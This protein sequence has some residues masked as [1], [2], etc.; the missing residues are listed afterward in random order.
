MLK[1]NKPAR[2]ANL[3]GLPEH[4][5]LV[6]LTK[7]ADKNPNRAVDVSWPIVGSKT[8]VYTLS[9]QI[10]LQKGLIGKPQSSTGPRMPE[11][12]LHMETLADP[13]SITPPAPP[14]IIW[15]HTTGDLELLLNL[16]ASEVQGHQKHNDKPITG[17]SIFQ[18]TPTGEFARPTSVQNFPQEPISKALSTGDHQTFGQVTLAG[19]LSNVDLPSV[20]QSVNLCKM[21][22]KLNLY[23][24]TVQA[25]AYFTDGTLVHATAQHAVSGSPLPLTPDQ[26]LLELLTWETGTFRFQPGWPA[27]TIT[28]RRRLESFLL[29]GATLIDYINSLEKQGFTEQSALSIVRANEGTLDEALKKGIPVE[30]QLQRVIYSKISNNTPIADLIEDLPKSIW[31]PIVFNLLN[32]QLVTMSGAK[33]N[34]HEIEQIELDLGLAEQASLQLG[35]PESGVMHF[36]MFVYFLQKEAARYRKS[37]LPFSM[38][39]FDITCE[40]P[41]EMD[42]LVISVGTAFQD[43]KQPY[44]ILANFET[45]YTR[46]FALLLPYKS[47]AASY[48]FIDGLLLSLKATGFFTQGKITFGLASF[49]TDATDVHQ[50]ASAASNAKKRAHSKGKQIATFSGV[51]LQPWEELHQKG[52]SAIASENLEMASDIWLTALTEAENFEETDARLIVTL[53]RLSSIY[54]IQRKFDMAEPLLKLSLDLKNMSGLELEMITTLDQ[55]GRCYYEQEKYV[56]SEQSMLRSAELCSN[57][58]GPEHESLGNVFHNLA[59][60]YHVQNRLAEALQSYQSAVSIKRRVLGREHPE[61]VQLTENY[62]KLLRRQ[63]Q[64]SNPQGEDMFITGRWKQLRFDPTAI[65]PSAQ[66]QQ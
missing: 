27:T 6:Q 26:I 53:D 56:E 52:D 22:G 10:V 21:T 49:P 50:L 2:L 47:P 18:N 24:K 11:W 23:H 3:S 12:T 61:V 7:E 35:R 59:T 36:P 33:D 46:E 4:N 25:E 39:L 13:K 58:Y 1:F 54:L 55:I 57:L 62:A 19:D 40:T 66:P 43:H 34:P 17:E 65:V 15:R 48:L 32:L 38:A 20:F 41:S 60:V 29:E 42:Q 16:I 9:C 14:V 44:D 45:P 30:L 28:I 37:K 8:E 64:P 31:A 63:N 51:E 5:I